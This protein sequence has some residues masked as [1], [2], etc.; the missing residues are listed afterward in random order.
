MLE[1]YSGQGKKM[2]ETL[3]IILS[4]V[5]VN[6]ALIGVFTGIVIWLVNKIDGDVKS[7]SGD[8]KSVCSRLDSHAQRIDQ[9]YKLFVETQKVNDQKFYDLLREGKK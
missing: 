9:L 1:N 2:S 8:L 5:G 7:L 3:T 6:V 4:V